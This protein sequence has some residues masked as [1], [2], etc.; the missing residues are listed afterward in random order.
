MVP[1]YRVPFENK[2]LPCLTIYVSS[3]CAE[4]YTSFFP[5]FQS[6][7]ISLITLLIIINVSFVSSEACLLVLTSVV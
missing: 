2:Y 4:F 3:F 1:V 6:S 7:V 5:F